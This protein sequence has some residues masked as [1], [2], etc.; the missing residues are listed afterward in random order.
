MESKRKHSLTHFGTEG[1]QVAVAIVGWCTVGRQDLQ[2]GAECQNFRA[3]G[4]R[5]EQ[6]WPQR[7]R[8][9]LV[10]GGLELRISAKDIHL[11][12]D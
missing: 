10:N 6:K 3:W 2:A 11:E 1:P 9:G 12:Y 4:A 7:K 8:K 5:G